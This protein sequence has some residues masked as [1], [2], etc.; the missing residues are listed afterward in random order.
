[1]GHL[2]CT[3]ISISVLHGLLQCCLCCFTE[4]WKLSVMGDHA[5]TKEVGIFA[6]RWWRDSRWVL[7]RLNSWLMLTEFVFTFDNFVNDL[8][9]F[10]N[11]TWSDKLTILTSSTSRRQNIKLKL[12][13]F[14][15]FSTFNSSSSSLY[16]ISHNFTFLCLLLH[17][18]I[19]TQLRNTG[20]TILIVYNLIMINFYQLFT[21]LCSLAIA[22]IH[23]FVVFTLLTCTS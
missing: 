9:K 21:T 1:M 11:I 16:T 19:T 23:I 14:S 2:I 4:L 10:T 18:N 8:S 20:L 15:S 13:T 12:M 3:K 6:F 5:C 22:I 17:L 7:G